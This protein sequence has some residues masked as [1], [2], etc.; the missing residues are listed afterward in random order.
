MPATPKSAMRTRQ[1]DRA[2]QARQAA[3]ARKA[4]VKAVWARAGATFGPWAR[5]E[6]CG[7]AVRLGDQAPYVTAGHVHEKRARSLGGNPH[8]PTQCELL[9]MSCHMPNGAHRRSVRASA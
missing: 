8:D 2:R 6:G 4:C 3:K 9:C 7:G 1:Q 5:C